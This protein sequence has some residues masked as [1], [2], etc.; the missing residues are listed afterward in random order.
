MGTTAAPLIGFDNLADGAVYWGGA[1]RG[2]LPL[3]NLADIQMSRLARSISTDLSST[4]F[5]TDVGVDEAVRVVAFLNHNIQFGGKYRLCGSNNQSFTTLGVDTG[6]VQVWPS[7]YSVDQV[8]WEGD[9]FWW[10]TYKTRDVKGYPWHLIVLLDATVRLRYW[11]FEFDDQG[12]PDGFVQG[13]RLFAGDAWQPPYVEYGPS[14]GWEDPSGLITAL[15]GAEYADGKPPCRVARILT[16][17]M[18]EDEM[19]SQPFEIQRRSGTW[20][21]VIYIHDKDD[22]LHALRRR[23]PARL[24]I[25]G[26]DENPYPDAW[27]TQWEFKER[28][29]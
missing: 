20:K 3:T 12:N 25:L 24:R 16:H 5:A 6:W 11:R 14:I 18:S 4:W 2:S 22:V 9:N 26:P 23:F 28:L 29:P 27:Q 8:E 17:F 1:W 15:S 19:F 13:G 10:G 21:E 7:V